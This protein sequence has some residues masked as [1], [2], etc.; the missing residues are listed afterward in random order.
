[1]SGDASERMVFQ[2][3]NVPSSAGKEWGVGELRRR[4]WTFVESLPDGQWSLA[5]GKF[6]II[7]FT[8]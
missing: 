3:D 7:R 6:L 8:V 5:F 4:V 2:R 1:M